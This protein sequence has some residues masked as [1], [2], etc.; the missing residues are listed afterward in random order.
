MPARLRQAAEAIALYRLSGDELDRDGKT[1]AD[2]REALAWLR[3]VADGR[4]VLGVGA[5][6]APAAPART[7]KMAGP[8]RVFDRG[9][10]KVF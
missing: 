8:A 9:A 2:H 3:D 5:A 7:V 10:M 6:E 4:A 1:A